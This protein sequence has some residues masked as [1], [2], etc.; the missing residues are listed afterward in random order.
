MSV[1]VATLTRGIVPSQWAIAYRSFRLPSGSGTTWIEGL[2]FDHARN[3]AVRCALEHEFDE[4][5]FLD[6]D[7]IV[8][9]DAYERLHSAQKDIIGALYWT[10]HAPIQPVMLGPGDINGDLLRVDRVGT[11]CLLIQTRIFKTLPEPW[12]EWRL[13]R[14]DLPEEQRV[15]EDWYFC[16]HAQDHGFEIW[17]DTG[18]ECEHA[19]YGK[20]KGGR[21]EPL[22]AEA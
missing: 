15:S 19:G 16:D 2:P 11:G 14:T 5:L 12:F 13:D 6:D 7:V 20:S 9:P 4:L 10:R 8:P 3:V 22:I 17:C 18:C 1:L 21:F